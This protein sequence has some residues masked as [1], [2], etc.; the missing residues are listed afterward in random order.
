MIRLSLEEAKE[1]KSFLDGNYQEAAL[2]LQR[3]I[4]NHDIWAARALQCMNCDH[5]WKLPTPTEIKHYANL[6]SINPTEAVNKK[7]LIDHINKELG[8]CRKCG[9]SNKYKSFSRNDYDEFMDEFDKNFYIGISFEANGVYNDAIKKVCEKNETVEYV[10][11]AKNQL[12][13]LEKQIDQASKHTKSK[14]K[15]QKLT[16]LN[17]DLGLLKASIENYEKEFG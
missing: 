1:L 10:K 6:Y 5:E 12:R 15:Q 11:N 13:E 14:A 2:Q 9:L 16:S 3:E 17:D 7:E 4:D 8:Y